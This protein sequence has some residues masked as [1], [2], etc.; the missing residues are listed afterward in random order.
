MRKGTPVAAPILLICILSLPCACTKPTSDSGIEAGIAVHSNAGPP[1]AERAPKDAGAAEAET[2]TTPLLPTTTALPPAVILR[3]KTL[4]VFVRDCTTANVTPG[5]E[6]KEGPWGAS[7]KVTV[8]I[9]I[10]GR[11]DSASLAVPTRQGVAV[12]N[13][14]IRQL[15]Q[16]RFDAAPL[17]ARGEVDIPY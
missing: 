5:L 4:G 11:M 1:S 7:L 9:A 12:D 13:C 10:D 14:I 16:Q 3:I 17:P 6:P 15:R 2:G 8:S